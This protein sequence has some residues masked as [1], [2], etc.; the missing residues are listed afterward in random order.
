MENF[1]LW[2]PETR[3]VFR[4]SGM[5]A[6]RDRISLLLP[7]VEILRVENPTL[8][9]EY[10]A[11]LDW[12][13]DAVGNQLLRSDTSSIPLLDASE[14]RPNPATAR[15]FPMPDADA[16]SEACDGGLLLFDNRDFFARHQ[17]EI[18]Y[19]SADAEF[20]LFPAAPAGTLDRCQERLND[21]N[22]NLRITLLG[23]SISEG[24]NA[25]AFVGVE[26]F[27]PNYADQWMAELW[28]RFAA[29]V[30]FQNCAINGAG[31]REAFDYPETWLANRADLLVIAYGMNDLVQL[32]PEEFAGNLETIM[33]MAL[34]SNSETEF[35][36]VTPMYGNPHWR[37]TPPK[38]T[39]AFAAAVREL[40]GRR[41]TAVADVTKVWEYLL[42]R[43]DFYDL[44]GN[45][46]NHPNDYGHRVYAA[47]MSGLLA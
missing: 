18:T 40:G 13:F 45:G 35:V 29:R 39:A 10:F 19:R 27:M 22:A 4:E 21:Q 1:V 11:G 37:L 25:T 36:L 26:P 20:P 24:Y 42:Q 15:L 43:K 6:G 23:D 30:S 8:G 41:H 7:A 38:C 3:T 12:Q 16:V 44:T 28:R 9:R 34:D 2:L 33:D 47:V 17:V 46:V 5:F 31:S 32:S 14:L